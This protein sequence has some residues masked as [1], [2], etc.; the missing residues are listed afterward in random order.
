MLAQTVE[1]LLRWVELLRLEI[2]CARGRHDRTTLAPLSASAQD[3]AHAITRAQGHAAIWIA[4]MDPKNA[5]QL[6]VERLQ[7]ELAALAALCLAIA[8]ECRCLASESAP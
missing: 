4:A 2:E 5:D 8:A 1:G 3:C 6:G 7:C